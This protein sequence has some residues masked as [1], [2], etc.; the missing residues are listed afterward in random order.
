MPVIRQ[1]CN[2]MGAY[3]APHHIFAGVS[4]ILV[5]EEQQSAVKIQALIV[6]IYILVTTR[7]AGI[8]TAPDTYQNRRNLA[9]EIVKNASMKDEADV[10]VSNADID[11]CMREVKDHKWTHMDW[12]RNITQGAGVG[13]D[14]PEEDEAEDGSESD[15]ANDEGVL[16]MTM[17]TRGREDFPEQDFLQAGLGTMVK[18]SFSSLCYR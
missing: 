9:L 4:S 18:T 8:E 11:E 3:A 13:L 5:S 14:L 7:L 10:D 2:Q 6:A 15:E 1:L 16:P 12:F 17:R